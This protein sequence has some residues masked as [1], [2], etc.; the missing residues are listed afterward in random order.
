MQFQG[1]QILRQTLHPWNQPAGQQAAGAAQHERCLRTALTQAG[2]HRAQLFKRGVGAVAQLGAGI[3]QYQPAALAYEKRSA[4]GFVQY[5]QLPAHGAMGDVQL[6]GGTAD[7][8]QARH[9]FE[10]PQCVQRR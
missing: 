3:G 10:R 4:Q 1:R 2:P 6:F 7:A 8:A 5:T 9:R